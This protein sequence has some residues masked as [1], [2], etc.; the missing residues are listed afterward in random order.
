MDYFLRNENP[1]ETL[2][3]REY[4]IR[5]SIYLSYFFSIKNFSE[6]FYFLSIKEAHIAKKS[7]LTLLRNQ[8]NLITI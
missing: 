4:G 3:M 6:V 8:L 2:K 5:S 7:C 1:D